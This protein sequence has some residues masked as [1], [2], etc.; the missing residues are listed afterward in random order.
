MSWRDQ[1]ACRSCDTE[2][3]YVGPPILARH[4]NRQQQRQHKA[5]QAITICNTCPVIQPCRQDALKAGYWG[6]IAGGLLPEQQGP[7]DWIN[8]L[9]NHNKPP[10]PIRH[11]TRAGYQAHRKLNDPPCTQCLEAARQYTQQRRRGSA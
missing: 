10:R 8:T 5:D 4:P 3:F 7:H 2:T 11:G 6:Y 1:A 9:I